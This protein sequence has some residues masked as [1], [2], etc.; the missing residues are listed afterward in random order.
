MENAEKIIKNGSLEYIRQSAENDETVTDVCFDESEIEFEEIYA[1]EFY[2]CTFRGCRFADCAF[3]KAYFHQCQFIACDFS[4]T[5]IYDSCIKDCV[6]RD[7]KL[8]GA[9]VSESVLDTVSFVSCLLDYM[10]FSSCK[11]S[12]FTLDSSTL[13]SSEFTQ[14]TPRGFVIRRCKI[15]RAHFFRTPLKGVDFTDSSLNSIV[16]SDTF[17]ELRGA[18]FTPSQAVEISRLL[19][20]NIK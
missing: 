14:C 12:L 19:K 2:R 1:A 5:S 10:S 13:F 18:Y 7:S 4:N 11:L 3:E 20:I 17:E 16:V 9:S 8:I 15:D 6:F